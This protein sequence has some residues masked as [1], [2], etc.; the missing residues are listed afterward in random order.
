MA[1]MLR[2]PPDDSFV[3]KVERGRVKFAERYPYEYA[4]I[5]LMAR[6]HILPVNWD[7]RSW[8]EL[9]KMA[10]LAVLDEI[11]DSVASYMRWTP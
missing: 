11:R 8:E 3:T 1:T 2:I 4:W 10:Q 9:P 7:H 5:E 6:Q